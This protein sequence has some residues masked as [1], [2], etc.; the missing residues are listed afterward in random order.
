M[1][2]LLPIQD[3]LVRLGIALNLF[4]L[5]NNLVGVFIP[6]VILQSGGKLWMIAG[7]YTL[8]AL[9]KLCLNLPLMRFIQ[10]RG[11]HIGLGLGFAFGGLELANILGYAS[12]S[13]SFFLIVGALSL[14]VTNSLIWN[15]QHVFISR[16]MNETTK[17]SSIA[18]IEIIGQSLDVLGPILGAVIGSLFGASWLLLAALLLIVCAV[19]ALRNMSNI[20]PVRAEKIR[21]SLDGA[22]FRDIAANFCF[23]IETSVGVMLWPIYLAVALKTFG[24]IGGVAAISAAATILTVSLAGRRG[25]QGKDRSVL[26]EGVVVSSA[27]HVLRVVATTPLLITV[28]GSIYKASL[29]YFQNSWTSTYYSHAKKHGSQYIM[30]MEIACDAAYLTLWGG[31]LLVLSLSGS[32][33][34]FFVSAFGVAAI[35]AWGCLL[36]SPQGQLESAS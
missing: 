28:I 9:T 4:R 27:V 17:S 23:N 34:L 14:A 15:A 31:L 5:G 3:E 35:A 8:Y 33:R 10:Q 2:K 12:T 13:N 24:A 22:P 32:S 18:S 6:L 20:D 25:D 21:Y 1:V 7:F 16:V 19:I 36:I 30:S 11:S 26:R 29:A